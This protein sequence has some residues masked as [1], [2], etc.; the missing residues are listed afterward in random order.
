MMKRKQNSAMKG[1]ALIKSIYYNLRKDFR[2]EFRNRFAV[3]VSISFALITTLAIS[4]SAGAA[5]FSGITQAILYWIILFFSA[6]N[7]LSHIFIRE[8]E[9]GTTLFL[10]FSSSPETVYI[11]K[12]LFNITV[13]FAVTCVITPL[14]IFFLG[15]VVY[16]PVQFVLVSISGCFA[17]ASSTTLLA[18]LVAKAGGKGPLFTI[19]SFPI[20][21][22]ILWVCIKSS[23]AAFAQ[24]TNINTQGLVF[25][26]AFSG[27][28]I[29]VSYILFEYIW[30]EE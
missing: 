17:I 25:L 5:S 4:L 15:I 9:E 12:L 1:S 3:S 22:P 8:E 11:A 20:V 6:M 13:L 10:R 14:Y 18:A 29:A 7:G 19:I 26:L 21:L 24:S 16:D 2:I 23:S 30:I 28:I 27:A